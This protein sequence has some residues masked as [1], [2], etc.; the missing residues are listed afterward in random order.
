MEPKKK[1]TQTHR[2]R[3]NGNDQRQGDEGEGEL[4]IKGYKLSVTRLKFWSPNI[5]YGDNG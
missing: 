5:Q 4:L 3:E 2:N 1:K